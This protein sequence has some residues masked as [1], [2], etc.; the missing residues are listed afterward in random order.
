MVQSLF[1]NTIRVSLTT[2]AVIAVLLL[3]LPLM[4]KNYTAKWRCAVWL[5][6]AVRLLIPF[7]PAPQ[8][9][10]IEIAPATQSITL[11]APVQTGAPAPRTTGQT[12]ARPAAQTA[13]AAARASSSPVPHTMTLNEILSL[14]WAAGI[15]LF[16]LY[17]L[18]GYFTF[19]KS[20]LRFSKPVEEQHI[21][22]LWNEIKK[23][24]GVRRSVRLLICKKTQS[25][26]MSGFFKPLLLLPDLDYSDADM[27]IILKHELIHY[28]RKDIWYKLL[29]VCA[30]AVHWFNPLVYLM[31]A[32]SNREL[33]MACDS[34]LVKD[35]DNA[36]RKQYSETILSAIHKGNQR[37]AMFST[38]FYG[39]KNTMKERFTNIFD[40][41]QKRKG[42]FALCA[43]ILAIGISGT[44]VA[45]GIGSGS[46]PKAIDN[47]ALLDAGNSY[48]LIDGEF[49]VSYGTESYA[50]V[51]L[52]PDTDDQSAYFADKAI[53]LSNEIT[54]VAYGDDL[55]PVKVLVSNDRGKT[56]NTYPVKNT[57]AKDYPQKKMG[58]TTRND[59]WLL[60][61]GNAASGHQESRIF[62]TSDG[63]KTWSEIGNTN[64]VYDRAV[65]GAGFA[66]ES[67]G[68]VSFRHDSG[69]N[70]VMYRTQDKGNT[71]TKCSLE[72]PASFKSITTRATALSPVFNGADGVLPVTLRN[73][74]W[75]GNPVDVTVR[76]KTS[77]YGKTWT[78]DEKYNLALIWADAWSTRDGRARYEIMDS[79]LQ[80]EFRSQQDSADP[81][82]I[83]WSSPWV[84][85]YHVALDGDQAVVTYLYTDSTTAT[86]KGVERLSFGSENGRTV[87]TN[88]KTEVDLEEY[89]DTAGWKSVDTGLCT[90]SIPNNWDVKASASGE[91]HISVGGSEIGT[92]SILDYDA[93]QPISQFEGNHAQM[94]S[95]QK[96]TDCKYPATK[97]V[98]RRTQPAAANDDSYV[99]ELHIYLIPQNSKYAYDLSLDSGWGSPRAFAIAKSLTVNSGRV[100][101]QSLADK[102]AAAVQKRDGKAQYDLMSAQLQKKVQDDYRERNWVT[103]QSSPWVDDFTV[104]AGDN[105]AKVTYTYMTSE[106]FAGYYEQTL[107]F[108]RENGKLVISGITEPK[109]P[110]EQSNGLVIS[111]LEDQKTYLSAASLKDGTFSDMTLSIDGRTKRF[112]WKTSGE[113]AFL[114]E[115]RYADVDGDGQDELIV[116]LCKGEGTGTLAEEVHVVNPRDFSEIPVQ[117]P[118]TALKKRTV[119]V[120]D[121]NGIKITIDGKR[122]MTFSTK[123]VSNLCGS[124][125]NWFGNLQLGSIV[126]YSMEGNRITANVGVQLSPSSFFGSY[127]LIYEYTNHQL[128]VSG[129]SF[130]EGY[131]K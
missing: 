101:N 62:Q 58:F 121:K 123:E 131:G 6:L 106:G 38:Y 55:S 73:D 96:L 94:L 44:T 17:H 92:L 59:G 61:A 109:Q 103:G 48:D 68:F 34:E 4:H 1:R 39:G 98:I 126:D 76:Y 112:F 22:E 119:S 74:H 64:H 88:C 79:K 63:G 42:I 30:N 104:K 8:Q 71:W 29:L 124:K 111:Y 49:V 33:E 10:P 16:L 7:A 120:I 97:A 110:N 70:P 3:L 19:K 57:K 75:K 51:P 2:S 77:D 125:A 102:W 53:Y 14:A 122:T 116:I 81:Y 11:A 130:S 18:I 46:A 90:F 52:A 91:V 43:I 107:S 69:V 128:V 127:R 24:V 31:T 89:V 37:Q 67:I 85:S 83:R 47:V 9:A 23:E 21:A 32:A 56:W 93:S 118:L 60:L 117:N 13:P 113:P 78:F 15:A 35:S 95:T 65:T 80:A 50:V 54:A 20:V 129:I 12:A 108:S 84:V 82:V 115:L 25:P 86:Y 36:F 87:V 100:E 27:K 99:D 45:Y 26:M 72:I 40:R 114:P 66:S 28:A 41:N 5:V 105:T